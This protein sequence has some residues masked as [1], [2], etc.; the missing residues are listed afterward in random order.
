[1]SLRR[2]SGGA[3]P[4]RALSLVEAERRPEL[5]IL[6]P[7]LDEART[8]R[9]CI[10][11]AQA[12]L[13]KHR[14]RGEIMVAD[15]GSRDGS[16]EIAR[17]LGA[18]VVE[19][20]NPGYGAA[21]RGG[22]AVA[23]GQF[24]IMGDSDGSY[25][26]NE[27]LP[28]LDRLRAGCDVVVGNRFQGGIE[29]GAMP[30]LHRYL[31]NPLLTRLGRLMFGSRSGDFYC[32]L[33]G[34]ARSSIESMELQSQGMEFA[35]EMLVKATLLGMRVEEVPV[36]LS[37]DGRNRRSHLRTW[38]DGWRSL[39]LFLV[40][41]PR[42]LFF[43]PALALIAVGA[44][45]GSWILVSPRTLGSV[46]LDVHTLLYCAAAVSV[47]FQ[48]AF[49]FVFGKVLAVNSGLH[50]PSRRME[51]IMK[52][53]R[54]EYGLVAGL[55]LFVLGILLSVGA[56]SYWASTSFGDLDP[57]QVMRVTI[58]AALCLTLGLASIGW[59]FFFS[60]LQIQNKRNLHPR[61]GVT[62]EGPRHRIERPDRF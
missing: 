22:I 11:D 31:G 2:T 10:Q 58:P 60:L 29:K 8:L 50:P 9:A 3:S 15:N 34:F 56:A 1:M 46:R 53:V 25:H 5:T 27:L 6:M 36:R 61:K 17:C 57:F 32:G 49:F 33:R 40:Y 4:L 24:V 13:W 18:S 59:S 7:C 38:R 62:Y 47:G 55:L 30:F 35:L 42:W 52:R 12:F 14:I 39:H 51:W 43:Y 44:G 45:L 54:F 16:P 37:P 41:S 19:V 28:I 26:F 20:P 21:L 23:H 48:L